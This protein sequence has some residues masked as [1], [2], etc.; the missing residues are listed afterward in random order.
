MTD[1]TNYRVTDGIDD[2]LAAQYNRV[3]DSIVRGELSNTE[4]L[5]ANKTLTNADYPL[6]VLSPTAARNIILPAVGTTNHPYYI[7]NASA[8]YALTVKNAG[9]T[10][11]GIVPVSSAAMFVSNG[12]AWYMGNMPY[13]APSTSGNVLISNGTTWT[14]GTIPTMSTSSISP[15]TSNVTAAK[16]TRYIANVSG[17]TAN[18]NFV[19]PA[20]TAGDVI[21]LNIST[22]DDTYALIIIGDTGITING[23]SA[24]TEWSRLFITNESIQLVATSASNWQVMIDKRI[25]CLGFMDRIT[26][27]V[28]TN[29]AATDT[30]FDWNNIKYNVGDIADTSN[31][32]FN[33][34]RANK[35]RAFIQYR[36][37]NAV[38]DQKSVSVLLF[39]NATQ[40][41]YVINRAPVTGAAMMAG[42]SGNIA[43]FAVGDYAQAKF[44]TQEANIGFT[45]N[46]DSGTAG[47]TWYQIEEIL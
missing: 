34:R 15:T 27:A 40:Y 41:G 38:T 10:T 29:T 37:E 45:R 12:T 32:R 13:V 35:Y 31:D 22:G 33:I 1:L 43:T 14:S 9:G 3:I 44:N 18:R 24:A 16:N 25:P 7:V 4:T 39:K 30:I 11:I 42:I 20:G 2:V 46:D 5:S 36:P 23:G 21:E 47:T 17:L 8:S 28:T 26:T 19:L 6:Q